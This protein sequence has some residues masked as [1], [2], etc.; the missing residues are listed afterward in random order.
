VLR[1]NSPH[2]GSSKYSQ[3][4]VEPGEMVFPVGNAPLEV[5]IV[6]ALSKQPLPGIRIVAYERLEDGARRWATSHYSNEEGLAVFDLDGL[7]DGRVYFLKANPYNGGRI[8][9]EDLRAPG[10]LE[11]KVGKLEVTVISGTDDEPMPGIVVYAREQRENDN[12]LTRARGV[13][14]EHGIIR[15]DLPGLGDGAVYDLKARSPIDGSYIYSGEIRENGRFRF[16]LGNA[17][18]VVHLRNALS[19]DPLPDTEVTAYE[20][21]GDKL[22]Y[23]SRYNTDSEGVA[24]FDLNFLGEERVFVLKARPYN[25]GYVY[26]RDI[27]QPG[28]FEFLVGSLE[29]HVIGGGNGEPLVNHKVYVY[30]IVVEASSV[31]QEPSAKPTVEEQHPVYVTGGY[32]DDAGIIRFDIPGL[33][34][35]APHFL[36]AKSPIDGTTKRSEV[37]TKIGEVVFRV[38]NAPLEVTLVNG[39]SGNRLTGIRIDAYERVDGHENPQWRSRQD[40]NDQGIAIFDLDGLGDGRIY[41]LKTTPY[42]GGTVYSEDLDATGPFT[43]RVGTL[44]VLLIS[45]ATG[46][47]LVDTRVDAREVIGDDLP[48]RAAG[49]SDQDGI[50]RFDLAGLGNG[51]T[52]ILE[53]R[54]PIDGTKK[55]SE[56]IEDEGQIRFVVG[57][58]PLQVTAINGATGEVLAGL[59]ITAKEI[60]LIEK[61]EPQVAQTQTEDGG[62]E[63]RWVSRLIT[64]DEGIVTFDLDGLGDGRNYLLEAQPYNGGTVRTVPIMTPG[65]VFFRVGTLPV[66][67]IDSDNEVPLREA[68]LYAYEKL[69]GGDLRWRAQG[70]TDD[71]G[72]IHFDLPGLSDN[73]SQNRDP[74][75]PP[76]TA[77][78]VF[79]AWNPF[80]HSRKYYSQFVRSEGPV[81]FRISREGEAPLD[82]TPPEIVITSPA[83]GTS[84]TNVSFDVRGVAA[85]NATITSVVLDVADPVLGTTQVQATYDASTQQWSATIDPAT[86][87]VGQTVTITATA[88]DQALNQA[89]DSIQVNVITDTLPPVVT[90]TS[91]GDGDQVGAAG[92]LLSGTATD[93]VGVTAMTATVTDPVLGQNVTQLGVAND[94]SWT[95]AVSGSSVTEGVQIAID[96]L[97]SDASGKMG[98][99]SIS[100]DVVAVDFAVRHL[101]NRITF[102]ANPALLLRAE[103]MGAA[104]FLAEQLDP[105]AIDDSALNAILPAAPP[106][107]E[108]QLQTEI[109]LRA[110]YS[111]RQLLEKVTQFWDNHFNTNLSAHDNVS[112]ESA[113][114]DLFRT[115]ALGRF[116]DLLGS[117]AQSPAMLYYLDQ[118]NS[119]AAQPNENYPREVMELHSLSVKG[120]YTQQDVEELA[121][122]L[123]GWTVLNDA[124]FF[125]ASVHDF[126]QKTFLG[127]DFPAGRGQVEG[128]EALD[129]LAS[130]SSTARFL[131]E[132]LAILLITDSPTAGLISRCAAEYLLREQSPTQMREVVRLLL[133]SPEFGDS[134][135]FRAK[136]KDPLEFMVGVAR[137]LGATSD[138]S[139]LL[140]PMRDMGMNLFRYPVPTGFD[141]VG[142][143]WVNSGQ[144][145]QRVRHA[146]RVARG[147]VGGTTVNL[148]NFFQQHGQVTANGIVGLLMQ[149]L[150]FDDFTALDEQ[151]AIDVLTD[152]GATPFDINA[153][154]AEQRLRET[155]ATVLSFPGYQFQ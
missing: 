24:I 44:E 41:F 67:L 80:G 118:A 116:R 40:T 102:G 29:V 146:N 48:W 27:R 8:Y 84:V 62:F 149:Y 112:Y 132:K 115:N 57:N 99:T 73:L 130:H 32:T 143:D 94:G 60:V 82:L 52:Y 139:S 26:S 111:E 121:R 14:D 23:I 9:S 145:L 100:L 140:S 137:N 2:D 98:S 122:I 124:F 126:G 5:T 1:A 25:G 45:G 77:I 13:T 147:T 109:V 58:L 38:G 70:Y 144:L 65:S 34:E 134:S 56:M 55:R 71:T 47:P 15:F 131:C 91:H 35:G 120:P 61:E 119:V 154:D 113:E 133:T 76:P 53:A 43:F 12:P 150:F 37:I 85:D 152:N 148:R 10:E 59:S 142:E 79:K 54:S 89:S 36:E 87:T 95:L 46:D 138:G 83:D 28:N 31:E 135:S 104:A 74:D 117:S 128:E 72:T 153:F 155:V 49:I 151:V 16:I 103:A 33:A 7:G 66:T 50:I 81:E 78:Y 127:I 21:H 51:R 69:P 19:G 4:I 63:T 101:I 136:I 106:S 68:K 108:S 17:P 22:E 105:A 18:L 96:L 88:S 141:E 6:N 11:W 86:L 90:I 92:F 114:N 75:G 110:I 3:E 20:R 93:D 39:I 42:N 107:S 125:D 97:A 64:N 129:I 123:T 30:R